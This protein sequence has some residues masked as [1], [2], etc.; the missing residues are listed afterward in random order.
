MSLDLPE[1]PHRRHSSGLPRWLEWVTA[2]SALVVSVCSIF[3][4]LRNGEIETKMVKANSFPYLVGVISDA[5]PE[6]RQQIS[7]DFYNNG[8]GPADEQ[9][10]KISV[11]GR[12]VKSVPDLINAALGPEEAKR[13]MPLLLGLHNTIRTR[14]VA[15]KGDQ[16]VF[17]IARTP[18]NA[19]VWDKL[20]ATQSRWRVEYCYCSVFDECWAVH[21]ETHT[22]VKACKRDEPN[23]FL[24]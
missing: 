20:D 6:G 24:P 12:Y 11:D 23:E 8:V 22:P 16:F 2:I 15:A 14:F 21:E 10:L 4:A 3:I 18:Q 1:S 9:S 13:A 7:M 5:T 19:A 17:R